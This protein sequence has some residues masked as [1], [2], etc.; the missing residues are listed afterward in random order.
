MAVALV[1][2]MMVFLRVLGVVMLLPGLAS[3]SLPVMLR[4]GLALL[5]TTLLVGVVPPAQVPADLWALGLAAVGEGLLGL[6]LGYIVRIGFAAVEF[7]GR[8]TSSEVGLSASPGFRGPDLSSEPLASLFSALAV[9]LFFLTGGHLQVL[10]ALAR[11][12]A[13]A[14][15]GRPAVGAQ[16]VDHIAIATAQVIEVGLR[17]ASPFIGLNFL[18]TLAF[19]VLGRAL[20]RMQVFV[21]SLSLRAVAGM[22][23]LSGAATLFARHVGLEFQNLP[24]RMLELVGMR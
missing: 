24:V 20:P 12:F 7:A 1:T 19:A 8:L 18:I 23:L 3:Y 4:V 6:A 5:L 14:A 10:G 22:L 9:I 17:I 16:S 15:P 2:G 21:I 13:L 11:S